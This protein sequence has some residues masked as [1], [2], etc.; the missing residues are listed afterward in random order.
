MTDPDPGPA[1]RRYRV[2]FTRPGGPRPGTIVLDDAGTA[3]RE[4]R[5]IAEAGGRAEVHYVDPD[6]TRRTLATFP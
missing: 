6:G 3:F 5:T 4:A 2:R 1:P